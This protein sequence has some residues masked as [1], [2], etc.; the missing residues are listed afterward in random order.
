VPNLSDR[1]NTLFGNLVMLNII[2]SMMDHGIHRFVITKTNIIYPQNT[3]SCKL[4]HIYHH[5]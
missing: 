2:Y 5:L 4:Q 1:Y 3:I